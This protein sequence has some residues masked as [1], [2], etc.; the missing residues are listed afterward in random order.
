VFGKST[1]LHLGAVIAKFS[2]WRI[3]YV[4]LEAATKPDADL[5]YVGEF[6]VRQVP[7]YIHSTWP[8]IVDWFALWS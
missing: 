6:D 3:E 1:Q 8:S 4:L 2:T 5:A 7:I